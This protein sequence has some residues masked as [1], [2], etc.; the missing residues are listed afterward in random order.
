MKKFTRKAMFITL[1]SACALSLPIYAAKATSLAQNCQLGAT[2]PIPG[3]DGGKTVIKVFPNNGLHYTCDVKSEGKSL[4]FSVGG[5]K[6][7][8]IRS[9]DSFY[10]ANPTTT[11]S[12]D[13]RFNNPENPQSEGEIKFTKLP[14][15]DSD[16]TVTCYATPK[17]D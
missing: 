7:F 12:I 1:A 5:G 14:F 4:K 3:N 2:C 8:K 10:N 17:E 16:G 13:G 6:N 9:G 15:S 11:I